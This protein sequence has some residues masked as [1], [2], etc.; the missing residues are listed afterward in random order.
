M[1]TLCPNKLTYL[2]FSGPLFLAQLV[3][4]ETKFKK[5]Y[6]FD[7]NNLQEGGSINDNSC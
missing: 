4:H 5:K 7:G 1:D 6:C 3:E 2:F